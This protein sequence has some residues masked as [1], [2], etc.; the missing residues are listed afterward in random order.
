MV[1]KY[2]IIILF[3]ASIAWL[4]YIL[5]LKEADGYI[6]IA[7]LQQEIAKIEESNSIRHHQNKILISNLEKI[8]HNPHYFETVARKILFMIKE[9]EVYVSTE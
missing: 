5:H 9:D 6:K 2:C 1:I 8:Q 4:Q 7:L 3:V